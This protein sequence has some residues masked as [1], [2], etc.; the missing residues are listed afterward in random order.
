[1]DT[2]TKMNEFRLAFKFKNAA[3]H[4]EVNANQ[5]KELNNF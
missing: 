4:S 1:M 5:I 2:L 3:Q